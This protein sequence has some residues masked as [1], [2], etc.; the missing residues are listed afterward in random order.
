MN[1]ISTSSV[2]GLLTAV[3][4]PG[5][6]VGLR[7][8]EPHDDPEPDRFDT[9]E[10]IRFRAETMTPLLKEIE[11]FQPSPDWGIND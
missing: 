9:I 2:P 7:P 11:G 8:N 3:T 10:A 5:V 4:T 1:A 6:V